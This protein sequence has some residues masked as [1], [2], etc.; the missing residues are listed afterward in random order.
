MDKATVKLLLESYRPQDAND[1]TFAEA[2]R[3]VAADP[4]LAE[5]FAEMQRFDAVMSSKF[6]EMEVSP[7]VRE[8]ILLGYRATP[9]IVQ[10]PRWRIPAVIG[11]IAAMLVA[12][13]FAWHL[14]APAPMSPLALQAI[15][16]TGKMPPLQF[17]CFDAQA[18]AEWINKQPGAEKVGFQI[19]PPPKSLSMAMIGS[20]IVD[21]NGHSVVMVA[22]QNNKR[23]A[24]LYILKA[25]DYPGLK[26]GLTETVQKNDWVVRTTN[27]D[28]QVR[29]LATKGGPEDLDFQMPF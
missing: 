4:E 24:M 7:D 16:Y 20:S 1:P 15:S 18:V 8:H 21:W 25:S 11:S 13:L 28:G 3:E 14:L 27:S 26:D 12:T 22:L 10:F 6:E 9:N 17:V 23:M 29:L 19:P 5:W 2:L